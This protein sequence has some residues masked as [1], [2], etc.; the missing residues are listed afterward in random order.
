MVAEV[1]DGLLYVFMPPTEELDHFIDLITRIEA[2]AA[3]IDCALIVEAT[4]RRQT[5]G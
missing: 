3:K 4:A 5:R 1:R 2:A